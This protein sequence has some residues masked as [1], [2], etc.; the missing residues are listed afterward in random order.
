MGEMTFSEE[1]SSPE[2]ERIHC[3][4]GRKSSQEGKSSPEISE[5]PRIDGIVGPLGREIAPRNRKNSL[6]GWEYKSSERIIMS[7]VGR[8]ISKVGEKCS[9]GDEYQENCVVERKIS[10]KERMHGKPMMRKV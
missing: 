4:E 7:P 8:S 6:N 5:I 3:L 9:S 10:W 1:K 2:T